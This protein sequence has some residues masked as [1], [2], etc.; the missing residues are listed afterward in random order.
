MNKFS[1]YLLAGLAALLLCPGGA[2]AQVNFQ[3][4]KVT[5]LA[6]DTLR[7]FINYQGWDI[8]PQAITFRAEPQAAIQTFRAADIKGFQVSGEQY[9]AGKFAIETSSDA[10][11]TLTNNPTPQLRI[12]PIFLKLIVAGPKSLYRHKSNDEARVYFYIGQ[13]GGP[14]LLIYKRLKTSSD[15]STVFGRGAIAVVNR[16]NKYREQLADYLADCPVTAARTKTAE[17]SFSSLQKLFKDYYANCT[18]TK[19]VMMGPVSNSWQFG[20]LLGLTRTSLSFSNTTSPLYL[21]L[22]SYT[23][24]APTGGL[25]A[26]LPLAGNLAQISLYN[27]LLYNSFKGSGTSTTGTSSSNSSTTSVAFATSYLNLNTMIRFTRKV[28]AGTWFFQGG[29][30]NG[31]AVSVQNDK[32]VTQQFYSTTTTKNDKAFSDFQRYEQGLV[33]GVGASVRRVSAEVR[34]EVTNG[35]LDYKDLHS[36]FRRYSLLVGYR[37]H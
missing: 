21:V 33:G 36:S 6:G 37:L 7:G 32:T 9:V 8:T 29:V 19:A 25:Y 5:T 27:E 13:P 28:G 14:E 15:G 4:A 26:N 10:L 1:I 20:A 2:W 12:E 23:Q 31:Y 34:A 30:S 17:Y 24:V 35:F 3:P 11:Q 18:S 22:D 16:N